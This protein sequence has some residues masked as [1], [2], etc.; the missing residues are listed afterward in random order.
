MQ[1]QD[2][3]ET[4]N[5]EATDLY[6][7]FRSWPSGPKADPG[8][9]GLPQSLWPRGKFRA[10]NS[11]PPWA[12]KPPE[13]S[14]ASPVTSAQQSSQVCRLAHLQ[15]HGKELGS[16]TG[17]PSFD[18]V[19]LVPLW[20]CFSASHLLKGSAGFLWGRNG[21]WKGT[22]GGGIEVRVSTRAGMKRIT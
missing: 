21:D 7:C 12:G 1:P 8:T 10:S 19:L 20:V 11:T 6:S 5:C 3:W 17:F 15:P 18:S 13:N 22:N 4:W 9:E 14:V 16:F 2:Q